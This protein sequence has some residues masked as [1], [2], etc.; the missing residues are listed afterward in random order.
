MTNPDPAALPSLDEVFAVINRGIG[1]EPKDYWAA[2]HEI[3]AVVTR[4][5]TVAALTARLADAAT[6]LREPDGVS[7]FPKDYLDLAVSEKRWGELMDA[8][9]AVREALEVEG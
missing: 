4:L 3:Q 2:M 5:H 7:Y 6:N 1:A 8:V 9:A